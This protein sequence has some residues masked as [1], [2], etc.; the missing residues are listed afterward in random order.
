MDF[1]IKSTATIY[2]TLLFSG[3][4]KGIFE[5]FSSTAEKNYK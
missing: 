4:M 1:G 3:Y 2:F 5:A